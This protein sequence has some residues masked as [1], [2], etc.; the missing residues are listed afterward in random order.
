MTA[1]RWNAQHSIGTRVRYWPGTRS[2]GFVE[3]ITWWEAW[4]T[5]WAGPVVYMTGFL[6]PVPIR[7]LEVV[8]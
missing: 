7:W 8:I 3:G 4:D 5:S 1:A 2:K 6:A